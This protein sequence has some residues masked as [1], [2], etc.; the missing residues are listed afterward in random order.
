MIVTA[1]DIEVLNFI[2]KF[3]AARTDTI[4]EFFYPSLRVA[5][6]RLK[7]LYDNNYLKRDR[8]HFTSQY[9]YYIRKTKQ[10]RH[11]LLLTDFYRE[12]NKI[13]DIELFEKEFSIADIRAD[14]LIAYRHKNK[15]YIAFVEIQIANIPLNVEKY[16]KLY[17]SGK[18]KKYFP[19]FPLVY[20]ITDQKIPDTKIEIIK[21][22]EDMSNLREVLK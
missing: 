6:R 7:L 20:A 9:Y 11:D 3:K 16:E 5:Q 17:H 8:D 10:L 21:V 14:G 4:H 1:R 19:V 13:V 18:Y 22:N 15:G 2:D 12:I